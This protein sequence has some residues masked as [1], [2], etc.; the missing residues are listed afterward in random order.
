MKRLTAFAFGGAVLAMASVA[1]A[2]E[3]YVDGTGYAVSGYDVVAYR[4][5][6]QSDIGSPQPAAVKGSPEFKAEHNGVVWLFSSAANRDAFKADPAAYAPAFDGHCAYG[7]A[8]GGK[9]PANPNLWR[10][11]DGQLYLNITKTVVGFW[12]EDVP[13]YIETGEANWSSRLE[14]KPASTNPVPNF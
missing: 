4:G 8:K 2:G 14:S 7:V 3:Q 11:V 12:E 9:V 5:L 1:H 6:A 10:I 13:G